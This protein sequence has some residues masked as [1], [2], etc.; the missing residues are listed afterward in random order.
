MHYG[1]RVACNDDVLDYLQQDQQATSFDAGDKNSHAYEYSDYGTGD[2]RVPSFRVQYS[3]GS[4]LSPLTYQSF[5]IAEGIAQDI[6]VSVPHFRFNGQRAS[7]LTVTLLDELKLLQ[8][9]LV[10]TVFADHNV[11][12]RH[13]NFENHGNAT[14]VLQEAN[15]LSLDMPPT[16]YDRPYYMTQL[17]GSWS[18]E[19]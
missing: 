13:V 19:R 15:S 4:S 3:D 12:V 9:Q 16:A 11:V 18:R 2:Y 8:V 17:S 14:V 7:T 6:P 10:Y 5:K 1:G